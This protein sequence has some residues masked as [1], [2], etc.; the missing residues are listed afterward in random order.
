MRPELD[1]RPVKEFLVKHGTYRD[2]NPMHEEDSARVNL[3]F[4]L[5]VLNGERYSR[6]ERK[7][8]AA[9][10]G[11]LLEENARKDY[12]DAPDAYRMNKRR[13]LCTLA[14]ALLAQEGYA[15]FMDRA[16]ALIVSQPAYPE[17][18]AEELLLVDILHLL[19][20]MT[21][22][23]FRDAPASA[24][25]VLR[26]S[27]TEALKNLRGLGKAPAVGSGFRGTRSAKSS[28]QD[29]V[30][31]K[32][33]AMDEFV[34]ANEKY[35]RPVFL[36]DYY[37][38]Q[39]ALLTRRESEIIIP[40]GA[41]AAGDREFS[42]RG[43]TGVKLPDSLLRIGRSAFSHNMLTEIV[44]PP[45]LKYI[46]DSAFNGNR[47][48]GVEIPSGLVEIG[49]AA[50]GSNK[51]VRL[52]LPDSLALIDDAVFADN[53]LSGIV[54]PDSVTSIGRASFQ[55]NRLN[56]VVLGGNLVSLGEDAFAGNELEKIVIPNSVRSIGDGA[57][58]GN[59]LTGITLG[60]GVR[61]NAAG[62]S[63]NGRTQHKTFGTYGFT[64]AH[65][66]LQNGRRGGTYSHD[67][68]MKT[69]TYTAPGEGRSVIFRIF[70]E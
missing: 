52:E 45:G 35:M 32:F 65:V 10:A 6:R 1:T 56:D 64:F 70:H 62:P 21:V 63:Y 68:R 14:L 25:I 2:P 55:A 11:K 37:R 28:L 30:K 12:E 20:I 47:L 36:S 42:G 46:G 3:V 38:L 17:L 61:F 5:V 31:K 50:F 44:L 15:S 53:R 43:L 23:R 8:A 60:S 54:I 22:S 58:H 33:A 59:S 16:C 39:N 67:R 27:F 48:G 41:T 29:L 26:D 57:F 4:S 69:W 66:Y 18:A 7:E 9:E 19:K 34:A 24:L 51:L 40:A 13:V 49:K